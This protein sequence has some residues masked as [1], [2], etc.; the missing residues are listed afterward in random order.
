MYLRIGSEDLL[1]NIGL[2]NWITL[3]PFNNEDHI[4]F[5]SGFVT[6]SSSTKRMKSM[7]VGDSFVLA[8]TCLEPTMTKSF[9]AVRTI[10]LYQ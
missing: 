4:S 6:I 8:F 7:I 2:Y 10:A 9:I 3:K 5:S 1:S